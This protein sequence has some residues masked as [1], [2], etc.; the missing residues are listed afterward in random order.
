MFCFTSKRCISN[1]W[2]ASS[3]LLRAAG[4]DTTE[5]LTRKF[6]VSLPIQRPEQEFWCRICVSN[7]PLLFSS[8]ESNGGNSCES[9]DDTGSEEEDDS[10]EEGGEED[11][12]ESEDEE[13]E[14]NG[15]QCAQQIFFLTI[16]GGAR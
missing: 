9:E 8:L 3:E 4:F 16:E 1:C 11:K 7:P 13:L 2:R 15:C 5:K 10:E 12:E 6:G 14:G